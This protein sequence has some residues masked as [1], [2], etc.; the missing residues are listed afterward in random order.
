MVIDSAFRSSNYGSRSDQS[1]SMIVLHATA[2]SAASALA[3]LTNPAARVSAHYLIE[4][5]GHTYQLVADEYA[6][7]HAGRASWQGQTAVN[8]CSIGIELA[9]DN[10]GRDGY[11]P[12]QIDAL[13]ELTQAKVAQYQIAP[14]MV[15]RHLDVALPRGR[16]TDPAGFPWPEFVAR[17]FPQ[18]PA[19]N[20]RP[21]RPWPAPTLARKLLAEAYRQVG[22][23]DHQDWAIARVAR[24]DA[25]GMPI[26]PSFEISVARR[27]YTAQSFGRETLLSP[28]GDWQHV[29]R[30]SA[31]IAPKQLPIREALLQGI[32]R[33]A[34]ETYHPDWTFHQYA[35]NTPIGPPIGA[36]FRIAVE[37]S[38]YSVACYA[39]DVIYCPVGHWKTIGRLSEIRNDPQRQPLAQ[40]LQAHWA[41]RGGGQARP[42]WPLYQYA[43]RENLGAPLSPSFRIADNQ[44]DYVAE[45][46]ALELIFCEID[47]WEAISRLSSTEI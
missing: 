43:L 3:W 8:E 36:S 47:K 45:A 15:T 46:F 4:K 20:D 33:Q 31:L 9:N 30:L 17:L 5:S 29:E 32:Y 16:K 34:G 2:G 7:W 23:V 40:A 12:E 10:S 28:T 11:P 37:G 21:P 44:H 1:I 26:G 22:A 25:L 19:P 41:D 18:A 27:A 38:Q 13:L 14:V 42:E 6:A 39:L 24:T 35:L